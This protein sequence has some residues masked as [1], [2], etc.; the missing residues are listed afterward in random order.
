MALRYLMAALAC[1][2]APSVGA[3]PFLMPE[4][5]RELSVGLGLGNSDEIE[6]SGRSVKAKPYFDARWSN[7]VFLSGQW[8]GMQLSQAPGLE[9]GPVV[10]A[11]RERNPAPGS[12]THLMPMF[13]AFINYRLLHNLHVTADG[14]RMVGSRGGSQMNLRLATYRSMAPHHMLVLVAGVRLSD[15]RFLQTNLDAGPDA[16]AGVQDSHIEGQWR[17]EINPKYTASATVVTRR[18]HGDAA[19]ARLERRP[20][21]LGYSLMLVRRF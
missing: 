10:T 14:F 9:Y 8:L 19:S 12:D 17:W 7:G 4:G 16:Q 15:R 18:L 11:A 5:T 20:V 21:S 2:A 3:S 6:R 13:G 1:L